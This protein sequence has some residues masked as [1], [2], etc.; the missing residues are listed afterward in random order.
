MPEWMKFTIQVQISHSMSQYIKNKRLRYGVKLYL[1]TETDRI[2][3]KNDIYTDLLDKYDGQAQAA[4][5][6]LYM[7][8]EEL[9]AGHVI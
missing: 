3:L 1:F 2:V 9:Y 4:N 5:I 8:D 6:V 7:T